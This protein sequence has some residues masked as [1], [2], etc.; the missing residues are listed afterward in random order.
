M[1]FAYGYLQLDCQDC[2]RFAIMSHVVFLEDHAEML[3][4]SRW[5]C[6]SYST[7]ILQDGVTSVEHRS[8]IRSRCEHSQSWLHRV[9]GNHLVQVR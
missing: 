2:S 8:Y 9:D 3:V 6:F 1:F 7:D 4:H 5:S